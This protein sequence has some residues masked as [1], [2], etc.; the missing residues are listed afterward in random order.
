MWRYKVSTTLASIMVSIILIC[1]LSTGE[2]PYVSRG[3]ASV[4]STITTS[5]VE[6]SAHDALSKRID[7]QKTEQD[8]IRQSLRVM[9]T[10][11]LDTRLY[12]T[13]GR[14]CAAMITKNSA[15]LHSEGERLLDDLPKYRFLSGED[16][17]IP[18]CNEY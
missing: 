5:A 10:D 11:Q 6:T 15:A 13:R 14:Q 16:W 8:Q 1:L 7:D 3:F 17:R 4:D 12:D 9:R 18:P 2:F